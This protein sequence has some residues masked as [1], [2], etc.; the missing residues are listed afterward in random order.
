MNS[1][2]DEKTMLLQN[3]L[4]CKLQKDIDMA[5]FEWF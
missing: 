1:F 4:G 5:F 2:Q 3:T